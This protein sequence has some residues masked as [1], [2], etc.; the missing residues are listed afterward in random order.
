MVKALNE[1][2]GGARDGW[3]HAKASGHRPSWR[4]RHSASS[5][6]RTHPA[7][8]L[9]L[10]VRIELLARG[11]DAQNRRKAGHVDFEDAHR[12]DDAGGAEV[13][14]GQR[15]AMAEGA[16]FGLTRKA[17]FERL[18]APS[19]HGALRMSAQVLWSVDTSEA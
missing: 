11:H 15:V 7:V 12:H 13:G 4:R 6:R 3:V 19:R 2:P 14:D 18:Q 16:G 1:T 17:L 8:Q 9:G 5:C 10:R